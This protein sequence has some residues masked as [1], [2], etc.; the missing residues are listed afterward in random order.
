MNSLNCPSLWSWSRTGSLP[1]FHSPSIGSRHTAQRFPCASFLASYSSAGI[2]KSLLIRHL[3]LFSLYPGLLFL[4][5][6]LRGNR[7]VVLMYLPFAIVLSGD[8]NPIVGIPPSL[9]PPIGAASASVCP[10]STPAK[11]AAWV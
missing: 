5:T 9:P 10:G 8:T 3:R 7:S 4:G 2:L 11:E 6:S 1:E